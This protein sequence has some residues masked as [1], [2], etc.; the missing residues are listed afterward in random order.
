[1]SRYSIELLENYKEI[2][3]TDREFVANKLNYEIY[4]ELIGY[5]KMEKE[6]GFSFDIV[7]KLVRTEHNKDGIIVKGEGNEFDTWTTDEFQID[8]ASGCLWIQV[9]HMDFTETRAYHFKDYQKTW[10]LEKEQENSLRF[11]KDKINPD[12]TK[13]QERD[14]AIKIFDTGC[15]WLNNTFCKVAF[16]E[17][18]E[19][20]YFIYYYD[21]IGE[22]VEPKPLIAAQL[23]REE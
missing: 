3:K 22:D 2:A 14:L 23:R 20:H 18:N 11:I 16:L 13:E 10:W 4:D 1:M 12:M 19:Y 17:K 15:F 21:R 8:F 7:M 9:E 6:L 5:K